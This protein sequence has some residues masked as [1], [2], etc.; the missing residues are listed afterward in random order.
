LIANSSEFQNQD[1][2]DGA[3]LSADHGGIRGPCRACVD[4]AWRDTATSTFLRALSNSKAGAF[5]I[6]SAS[7]LVRDASSAIRQAGP[8][9][10]T[11]RKS[12]RSSY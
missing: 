5:F 6:P 4:L 12:S 11:S 3:T 8:Q 1:T 9:G 7:I 2:R 10:V